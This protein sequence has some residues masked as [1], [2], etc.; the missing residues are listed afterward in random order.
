MSSTTSHDTINVLHSL[1]A[2][3]ELPYKL[4]SD[5]D[6]VTL[7]FSHAIHYRIACAIDL[8]QAAVGSCYRASIRVHIRREIINTRKAEI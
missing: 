7:L 4:V 8:S 5:N 3:H 2:R 6:L 1:F